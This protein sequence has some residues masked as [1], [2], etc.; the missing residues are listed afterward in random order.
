MGTS[1]MA[2][3][4]GLQGALWERGSEG[5]V[6]QERGSWVKTQRLAEPFLPS[7]PSHPGRPSPGKGATLGLLWDSENQALACRQP[8]SLGN[9]LHDLRPSASPPVLS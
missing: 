4:P 3:G 2:T 6:S 9:A 7:L 5:L 8:M 1:R